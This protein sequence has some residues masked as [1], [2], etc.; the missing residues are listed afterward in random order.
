MSKAPSIESLFRDPC[1]RVYEY[2]H[3]TMPRVGDKHR[4]HP[5]SKSGPIG[6]VVRVLEGADHCGVDVYVR[7]P[8]RAA[9]DRT[10]TMTQAP[11]NGERG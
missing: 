11:N 1:V 3:S 9:L 10:E 4:L 5:Y 7:F 2:P 8:D 6:E